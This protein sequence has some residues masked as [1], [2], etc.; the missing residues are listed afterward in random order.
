MVSFPI[1]YIFA[2]IKS[3]AMRNRL[4]L[5]LMLAFAGVVAKA[6]DT[7][8]CK[9]LSYDVIRMFQTSQTDSIYDLFDKKMKSALSKDKLK[10]IWPAFISDDDFVKIDN[11]RIRSY[12]G[13]LLTETNLVF[14]KKTYTMRLAFDK[15]THIAGMFFVP[16]R[17]ANLRDKKQNVQSPYYRE[18]AVTVKSGLIQLPG[19]L[20]VPKGSKHFPIVVFVHGS[21]PNDRDETIGPNKIFADIAHEL[22][23]KGIASLRYDKR[24]YVIKTT[25]DTN[26][27]HSGFYDVVIEDAVSALRLALR[28]V[29]EG[30]RVF[31]LGHSLGAWLAP[32]IAGRVPQVAGVIMMAAPAKPLEDIVLEQFK[33]LYKRNGY[34]C[35]ERKEIHK[36]KKKVR[37]VKKIDRYLA[38]KTVPEL[39]LVNDTAFWRDAFHYN[40]LKAAGKITTPILILQGGRDYQV[41]PDNFELWKQT[42]GNKKNFEFIFYDNLNHIF[43]EGE[44]KSYPE[45]YNNAGVIPAKVMS[46]ITTWILNNN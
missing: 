3:T 32:E 40:A 14:T 31:L 29:P 20:C 27:P 34:T 37:N 46:D 39:P 6:Q 4:I 2:E 5:F 45:E 28:T 10:M 42:Y 35:T 19:T 22:A 13:Y 9:S 41:T 12:Q 15:E 18:E 7:T 24:T 21:G 38:E 11:R 36:L 30:D 16:V 23:K 1:Y 26:I 43:H 33:Y 25:G 44:G 8:R 17:T